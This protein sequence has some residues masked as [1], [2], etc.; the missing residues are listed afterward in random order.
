MS[1]CENDNER[2]DHCIFILLFTQTT[3][4]T[5]NCNSIVQLQILIF[6]C[7]LSFEQSPLYTVQITN[8]SFCVVKITSTNSNLLSFQN[9][10]NDCITESKAKIAEK[11]QKLVR[12]KHDEDDVKLWSKHL[13][14]SIKMN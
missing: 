14:C 6:K 5:E 8:Q 2:F 4:T 1:V 10:R 7:T 9:V 12:D 13:I 3:S 11:T